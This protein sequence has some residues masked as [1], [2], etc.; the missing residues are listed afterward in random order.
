MCCSIAAR[1]KSD[2]A[3]L[4][5]RRAT[6]SQITRTLDGVNRSIH[7]TFSMIVVEKC[8]K[9]HSVDLSGDLNSS[10]MIENIF[11]NKKYQ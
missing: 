1:V 5:T 11:I 4:E 2:V 7:L 3:L 6:E 8:H 10:V 9:R